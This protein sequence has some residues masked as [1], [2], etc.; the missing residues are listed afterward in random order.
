MK[1][2][3]VMD[4]G[5]SQQSTRTV[6]RRGDPRKP[7][8]RQIAHEAGVSVATVSRV[9]NGHPDVSEL[10][11]ETVLK[12]ARQNA[13]VRNS[14]AAALASGRTGLIGL[15]VPFLNA[16]YFMQMVAGAAT[17]LE[18][19]DARFVVSATEHEHAR[20]VSLLHRIMHGATDGAI[21]IEPS[22][23]PGELASLRNWGVPF[24]VIDPAQPT[25]DDIPTVSAA[26][27]SGARAITQHLIELGHRRIGVVTGRPEWVAS[28]DRLG[29]YRATMLEA[30]LAVPPE[31]VVEGNFE[32]DSGEHGARQLLALECPPTA[33]FAFNDN[34]AVGVLSATRSLGL[35]VPRD[36]SIAGYDDGL[37]AIIS[38]PQLTTVKQPLREMGRVS[39]DILYRLIEKQPVEATR[40]ELSTKLVVRD[41]TG[42]P[43]Q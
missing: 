4:S 16:E 17:A 37:A 8:I 22:E 27:W 23:S 36:L 9:L 15:A 26:H 24:V 42:P 28:V 21:L 11:R 14:S 39:V 31:L 38:A 30:G 29:G 34:M 20:E 6:Q 43:G 32:M 12:T 5:Q 13:Y 3:S 18:E 25:G 19:H 1:A 10:T 35:V 7:T 41:S 2:V 40:I 33:I